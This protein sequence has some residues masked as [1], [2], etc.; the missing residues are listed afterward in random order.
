MKNTVLACVISAAM[1]SAALPAHAIP[2]G[3]PT[4]DAATGLIL[5]QNAAAQAKQAL[6]LLK[7][8]KEGIDQARQQYQGYRSMNEGNDKLGD[9]LNNPELNEVMPM[10]DWAAIYSAVKDIK[11]LRDQYKLQSDNA[12][13]QAKFDRMISTAEALERV[14]DST[15]ARV[16][17]ARQLRAKLNEVQT[18]QQK[19]D[20]QLRYQQEYLEVQNQQ[21]QLANMERLQ[22]QQEKMENTKRAE[23][24]ADYL[25]GK[26]KV[27]PKYD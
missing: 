4:L 23:A 2:P 18:P 27:L 7:Q 1:L 11:Q 8:T 6:D 9:F 26:S 10:G 24:A 25:S 15:T 21:I 13:V 16:K 14:Y 17:N 3:V 12:N 19:E 5:V 20:L 22:A